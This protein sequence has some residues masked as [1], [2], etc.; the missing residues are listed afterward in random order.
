M[1]GEGIARLQNMLGNKP[2]SALSPLLNSL[3]SNASEKTPFWLSK[4]L[5]ISN[6]WLRFY[7]FATFFL[8]SLLKGGMGGIKSAENFFVALLMVGIVV[9]CWFAAK[10]ADE[11][12][13]RR[14]Q[15]S[16]HPRLMRFSRINHESEFPVEFTFLKYNPTSNV[17]T[18]ETWGF[19][20][21]TVLT[22]ASNG[23]GCIIG[24][25]SDA[26]QLIGFLSIDSTGKALNTFNEGDVALILQNEVLSPSFAAFD[27]NDI[28]I[29]K[30][31]SEIQEVKNQIDG[32]VIV[33]PSI[34]ALHDAWSKVVLRPDEIENLVRAQ[35]LFIYSSPSAPCGIL[36]KGPPGTG[37]SLS[38]Q[39]FAE[40]SG[41]HFFKL[42]TS[43]LKSGNIGGSAA[44]VKRLWLEARENTP[45]VIF[46]DEC[47]GVF[48]KRGSDQSDSFIN[49]V[50]QTFLTEW[51]GIGGGEN[52]LVIGATNRP[53]LLD[54][55]IVSRFTDILELLPQDSI[56][57][58]PLVNAVVRQLNLSIVIPPKIIELMIGMNG[59]EVRN[60]IQQAMRLSAPD[61]PTIEQ[62]SVAIGKIRG[63]NSTKVADTAT[64]DTLILPDQLKNKIKT[65]AQ[66]IREAGTLAAQGI[67][68]PRTLLLYGPPGTG[69]TQIA[70]TMA[71]QAGVS[72]IARTTADL[73][74]QYLGHAA[75][76]I[77]QA[78][79][80]ARVSSPSI[81]FIDEID[82]LAS[83]RGESNDQLQAE[84]VQQLLQ[85]LDGVASKSGYVLVVA[86]TNLLNQLDSAILS[87]F[88][89]KLEIPLPS[90]SERVAILHTLLS[91]RPVAADVD[92]H[93]VASICEGLSGRD[94]RE[95]VSQGFNLAFQRAMVEGK[96]AA[97]ILLNM[98]DLK[99]AAVQA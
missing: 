65:L 30:I 3:R 20:E 12:A 8:V 71:N 23:D 51:D 1:F 25:F 31:Y 70:K 24:F 92:V 79:E 22:H 62:L 97:N 26:D 76:R 15:H 83:S 95:I 72:F 59:R 21:C 7:F 84:A 82:A 14:L 35:M 77:S 34:D 50:V 69:K 45:S 85:E 73:K 56:G 78:F 90:Q 88:S 37:K 32:N 81:L 39:I 47:E 53:E 13:L 87:R 75:G 38:A 42:S 64:W 6:E 66:M 33:K 27:K 48:A 40:S 9:W 68:I 98:V 57:M 63:K 52:I 91:G 94:L 67:P 89:Q 19:P 18:E 10:R 28:E 4:A 86:A 41:A 55:A 93:H 5:L 36:L 96:S 17:V 49:E 54:D 61:N 11:A 46:I 2:S 44:N 43:D 60:V 29:R 99:E 58:A 16:L 74:G 80:T